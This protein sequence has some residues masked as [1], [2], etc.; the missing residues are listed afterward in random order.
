M[1]STVCPRVLP[2]PAPL[3]G[4]LLPACSR[5]QHGKNNCACK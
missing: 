2:A 4:L 3:S 1:P 5:A